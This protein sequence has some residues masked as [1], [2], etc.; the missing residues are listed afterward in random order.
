MNLNVCLTQAGPQT[1]SRWREITASVLSFLRLNNTDKQIL[2]SKVSKVEDLCK[3]T[4]RL[5]IDD[6]GDW[7]R[8]T[9]SVHEGIN[10][11]VHM[12]PLSF[13][14]CSVELHFQLLGEVLAVGAVGL[15]VPPVSASAL[16]GTVASLVGAAGGVRAVKPLG[17]ATSE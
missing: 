13:T 6:V 7:I 15:L 16:V 14:L 2:R 17:S 8:F 12:P 1:V 5:L 3:D 4:I 9:P 11:N 10:L